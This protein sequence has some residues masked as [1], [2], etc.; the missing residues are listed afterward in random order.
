MKPRDSHRSHLL[1]DN[2]MSLPVMVFR[3]LIELAAG[4]VVLLAAGVMALVHVPAW[5][6]RQEPP[7]AGLRTAL[8]NRMGNTFGTS[9]Y[10]QRPPAQAPAMPVIPR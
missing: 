6:R 9:V 7:A 4:I 8:S 5:P 1:Q 10:P 3:L 2:V